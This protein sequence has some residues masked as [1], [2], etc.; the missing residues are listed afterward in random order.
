MRVNNDSVHNWIIRSVTVVI[1]HGHY[2]S[3]QRYTCTQPGNYQQERFMVLQ[4]LT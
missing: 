4:N 1:L 2:Q 3:L